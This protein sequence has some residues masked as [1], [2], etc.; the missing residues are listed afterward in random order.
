MSDNK[1]FN[2]LVAAGNPVGE[3]IAVNRWLVRLKGLNPTNVHALIMFED[4]SKGFVHQVLETQVVVLH[5]GTTM[6]PVGMTAVVQHSEL[7]T[8]IGKDYIGRVVSV[9]GEPLD[10]K[11]PI[12]ADGVRPVFSDAPPLIGRELLDT[13]LASGVLV[14]DA[15]FPIVRGQRMALLGD[16]KSGKTALAT[17]LAVNQKGSDVIT[18]YVL[19][20]KRR[21][22]IN[23]LL[24]K[25]DSTG[26]M[27]QTIVVVATM[28]ESLVTN[29]L[30]PYVGCALAE[31][32]WQRCDKDVLI[33]YDDL[34]SH[35]QAH[36]EIALLSGT[37]PGRDSYPGDM[38]YAHS[39][40]LERAGRLASNHKTL[41]AIPIVLVPSGDITAYLPTNIMS[42]TDGQWI[43]DMQVFRDLFRPALNA[44]LSVTRVGSRGHT[45]RQKRQASLIQKLLTGFA[46][47]Q[48][49]AHFSSELA[50]S[51]Q[52]DLAK[53]QM[54]Y[55]LFNQKYD[56]A[57][58]TTTQQLILDTL[59]N[60]AD[61][62]LIDA[63][64]LKLEASSREGQIKTDE[65]FT[66]ASAEL[67]SKALVR[68]LATKAA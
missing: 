54:L 18:V 11:G 4:G 1:H 59:L 13:Q 66:K 19:I 8:K 57:Y 64:V 55:K 42:I 6:L 58:S 10:G 40:L 60:L 12:A 16:S 37:S 53:G 32:L 23:A 61:D 3:V 9:N 29:Y 27:A 43:L 62:E 44:G 38:F 45:D 50:L 47:A 20:A 21:S 63:D 5:L 17:Q 56:E 22:D 7:V 51:T 31:Y 34:T 46:E 52:R 2:Q 30:A 35:A 39:S 67:K 41:T 28:L 33:I 48:E 65:D 15:L 24:Q 14:I 49:Y 36:R 26:A 25:L 68:S